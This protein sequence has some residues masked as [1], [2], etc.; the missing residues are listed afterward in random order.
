M[1]ERVTLEP[2]DLRSGR[3]PDEIPE[4]SALELASMALRHWRAF[5]VFPAICVLVAAALMATKQ[6]TYI[7]SSSL[8]AAGSSGG[9]GV[10]AASS[11][12]QQFGLQL[13]M[14]GD[15]AS[16]QFFADLAR[17]RPVL[18]TVVRAEY[19][20]PDDGAGV[21]RGTL[22]DY[23]RR[24]REGS[25]A[26]L[27][28]AVR[29]LRDAIRTNVTRET[30]VLRITMDAPHPLLAE[31]V[32]GTL[33]NAVNDV[34][35]QV[36][37]SRASEESRFV[38]G[39]LTEAQTRLQSA[40]SS[41]LAFLRSN[42]EFHNSPALQFEHQRLQRDVIMRQEVYTSLLR[43]LEQA[44][45]D[46]ARDTRTITMIDTPAGTAEPVARGTVRALIV[47]IVIGLFLAILWM[48]VREFVGSRQRAADPHYHEFRT[49]AR[50]A[51]S[52]LRRPSRWLPGTPPAA[53]TEYVAG[54]GSSARV[55]L[56]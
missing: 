37:Q 9:S 26:D 27:K 3:G 1:V 29:T 51:L 44:R 24:G 19:A 45:V 20:L 22:V 41:L 10:G 4:V 53:D 35:L 46:A 13:G 48:F 32:L 15:G 11:L 47:A 50:Q 2:N 17:S 39:R 30:G 49:L 31:Q 56:E 16:V 43:A 5:M 42:R 38:E 54:P 14:V 7:A 8:L 36:Q 12:A 21:W 25:E 28:E 40:E 23:Y 55:G 18:Q 34:N 6:R 33:V 52:D